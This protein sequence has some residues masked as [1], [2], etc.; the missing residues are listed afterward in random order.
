LT[1]KELLAYAEGIRAEHVG[2]DATNSPYAHKGLLK[3]WK[4][5]RNIMRKVKE[6]GLKV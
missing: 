2:L 6:K 4:R 1:T 3:W 5:G